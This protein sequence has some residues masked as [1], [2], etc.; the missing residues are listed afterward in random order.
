VTIALA[1]G[2]NPRL[3][4]ESYFALTSNTIQFGARA[5]LF[6]SAI[7]FSV[8]GDI[9]FDVLITRPLHF[10]ADF[11]ASVQL[12]RGST[13]LFKVS[14]DGTLEGP[15]PLRLSGKAS[16]SILWCDFTVHFNATLVDGVSALLAVVDVLPLLKAAL[17]LPTS[18]RTVAETVTHGVTLRKLLPGG[19]LVVDPLGQLEVTQDVVPLGTERDI[20]TFSGAPLAADKRFALSAAL[21]GGGPTSVVQGSFAPAQFFTMTDDEKL[22]S[23]SFE[24]HQSGLTV[25][26]AGVLYDQTTTGLVAAPLT[27]LSLVLDGPNLAP[28]LPPP[29]PAGSPPPPPVVYALPASR[30]PVQ[31]GSGA[32]ARA[33][34]RRAGRARYRTASAPAVSLP[35]PAWKIVPKSD[36]APLAPTPGVTTWSEHRAVV[37]TLNRTG[38]KWQVVPAYEVP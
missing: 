15:T 5:S 28:V 8:S 37:N 26:S 23:P 7:G 24:T 33:P 2:S 38:A 1:A 35:E 30:L 32:A 3:L 27:Y 19:P 36:G 9:G 12:K 17:A 21:T 11:H 10:I 6:A 16:F 18:W 13:N 4:C 14:V 29:P 22:A 20:E 34:I 25:G 31:S